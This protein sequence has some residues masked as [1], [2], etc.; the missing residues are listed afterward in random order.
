M[1]SASAAREPSMDEILASIRR[2]IESG[3]DRLPAATGPAVTQPQARAPQADDVSRRA[4]PARQADPAAR[5]ANDG[6]PRGAEAANVQAAPQARMSAEVWQAP[7]EVEE[8]IGARL[9]AGQGRMERAPATRATGFVRSG[10]AQDAG[11][12]ERSLMPSER[13]VS[14]G[15]L[16]LAG[17]GARRQEVPAAE[18][19]PDAGLRGSVPAGRDVDTS[20]SLSRP[21]QAASG[22][23]AEKLAQ[24]AHPDELPQVT[25]PAAPD[26]DEDEANVFASAEAGEDSA[27]ASGEAPV[28]GPGLLA[29]ASAL[30]SEQA[31]QQV[32]ASFD[33]LALAIREGQMRSLE[34]M[35][36]EML[37][38]MLQEW[39][40][41]NLPHIVER[42]VREEIER[43]ARGR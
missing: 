19:A 26:E 30:L 22:F 37:R 29:Q 40:D 32:A 21:Q 1:S 25:E 28:H 8:A 9:A 12:G 39:L 4:A 34:P 15:S 16:S 17:A 11:R 41:D 23:D 2:I 6:A 7:V 35:A 10:E 18:P 5:N 43:M 36:R 3:E 31:G 20:S 13:A 27:V 38:P 42:L 33:Q 14:A 24:P